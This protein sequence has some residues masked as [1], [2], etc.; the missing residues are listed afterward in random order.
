MVIKMTESPNLLS[1]SDQVRLFRE[2]KLTA[3]D[4][5]RSHLRVINELNPHLNSFITIDTK[6]ALEQAKK[7][8]DL[9]NKKENLGPLSG[10]ILGIKDSIPTKNLK[11]T[12]NS[13]LLRDWNPKNDA[14]VVSRLRQAGA[15]IIGKTNLNEFGWSRPSELDLKPPPWSPWNPNH[16]S[17]GSSSGSGAAA[18]ARMVSASIGTDGG[19]SVRLPAGAHNLYGI[20][21]THGL[22]S[23]L[24]MDHNGHSEISPLC[25]T[26]LDLAILLE[27]MS[28]FEAEDDMSWPASVP[29]YAK[30][31]DVDISGWKIGV[32]HNFINS[33]P[34]EPEIIEA[35][36]NFLKKLETLG[37][38][39]V[40]IDLRGMAETRAANF[41]VLNSES[42]QR[43]QKSLSLNWNDYGEITRVYLLQGAFISAN[44][45]LNA[46]EVGRAF[47]NYFSNLLKDNDLKAI[48]T[49]TAPFAT[50]ERSRRPN[51]HS[52][53]V[54]A[55][56]TAPFNISGHPSISI[57]AGFG[58]AGIPVGMML[59]GEIHDD[60]SLLQLAY[61]YDKETQWS[62][63]TPKSNIT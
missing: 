46:A 26:A 11:T 51:E 60:I 62:D 24:G 9:R 18:S 49:P 20:K 47:R 10:A 8:D 3:E 32:P 58:D 38:E 59:T 33:A 35:F 29:E 41:I 23:R 21:P 45:M 22:V 17:V 50:A 34:N 4:N 37:C 63:I 61:A 1:L 28:G 6:G 16:M 31:I 56:F 2:G 30:N 54:N 7:L 19:G 13:R 39:I 15:I 48:A 12:N 44:D 55:C 40:N 52:K 42:Y 27:S 43:H 5:V 36:E 25:R 53:G 14:S 57:P